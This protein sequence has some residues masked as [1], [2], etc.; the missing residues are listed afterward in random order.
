MEVPA[1]T[2]IGSAF[3][4]QSVGRLAVQRQPL[5]LRVGSVSAAFDC[6]RKPPV[7]N[8]PTTQFQT[9]RTLGEKNYAGSRR[10]AVRSNRGRVRSER[11]RRG[12]DAC[13]PCPRCAARSGRSSTWRTGNCTAPSAVRPNGCS[14]SGRQRLGSFFCFHSCLL[15]LP[16]WDAI[17]GCVGLSCSSNYPN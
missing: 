9:G 1:E 12:R 4:H 7:V 17:R 6:K 3:G 14:L 15:L 10:V 13:G 2:G 5:R 8:G 16:W 11:R